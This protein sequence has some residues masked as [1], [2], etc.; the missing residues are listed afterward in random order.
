MKQ[1]INNFNNGLRLV[2]ETPLN[3]N[4]Y[5]SLMIGINYGSVHE[6]KNLKGSAHFI[7]HLCFKGNKVIKDCIKIS[8]EFDK[9]GAY[10]NAYTEK[11]LTNYMVVC[12]NEN[13]D[14]CFKLLTDMVIFSLLLKKDFQKEYNV[15][16]EENLKDKQD[17]YDL[18]NVMI[19]KYI[20]SGSNFA[21]PIDDLDFHKTKL[22]Y[23]ELVEAYHKYYIPS[24]IVISV[25]SNIHFK[26]IK[27]TISNHSISKIKK[28][29]IPHSIDLSFQL[30][31][32][33]H[34][35]IQ[36]NKLTEVT[37]L[38][39][40]FKT[41]GYLNNDIHILNFLKNILGNGMS[42]RLFVNFREKN[43]LTYSSNCTTNYFQHLGDIT[44]SCETS[45]N[46]LFIK[47]GVM[48]IFI[49]TINDLKNDISL[50]EINK[51]KGQSKGEYDV[52]LNDNKTICEFNLLSLIDN[53]LKYSIKDEFDL[54]LKNISIEDLK[55]VINQYFK[56]NNLT[57]SI[58]TNYNISKNKI[59]KYLEKLSL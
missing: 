50:S 5:S 39:F 9:L 37:Y 1:I 23:H 44:L 22:N 14:K 46:K 7:E 43:G 45:Y 8:E 21:F 41:C 29:P 25:C 26:N 32:S 13:F 17:F 59:S 36:S 6:S 12:G 2:Y 57:V 55:R 15:I 48:D 54:K 34:I 51:I 11:K 35:Q 24:N 27:K 19:D 40:S 42:S 30:Q 4:N 33:P 18:L 10:I 38:A 53:N 16:L 52:Q 20:Y 58:I 28:N 47:N 49:K 56:K 31:S 3:N